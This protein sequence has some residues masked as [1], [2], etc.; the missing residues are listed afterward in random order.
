MK[1]IIVTCCM[2]PDLDGFASAIA[3]AEFLNKTG[4]QAE[5]MIFGGT[6]EEVNFVVRK[7]GFDLPVWKEENWNLKNNK[8]VL[9]DASD[10]SGLQPGLDPNNVIEVIDHRKINEAEIFKNAKIH[11][12]FV[13]AA[14]TLITEKF[15]E[16]NI[17]ISKMAVILLYSAIASNTLNFQAKVTSARDI[18]AADWL[19]SKVRL[20]NSYIKEM[21]AAKSD[22]DGNKLELALKNDCAFFDIHQKKIKIAQLEMVGAEKMIQTRKNE[23]FDFL[24][25]EKNENRLDFI[26]LTISDVEKQR[27]FFLTKDKRTQNL[28]KETLNVKFA[29]GI[30]GRK[31]LIMRKEI[32]PILKKFLDNMAE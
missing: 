21:F 9:V 28:L 17:E 19:K 24:K 18:M 23:I 8:I 16:K 13:G 29:D 12:D 30:A 2:T 22:L 7:F 26:F 4:V 25:K 11:I 6:R 20:P 3:Y 27:N 31:G 10:L 32:V 1:P 14:A 5:A 15:I